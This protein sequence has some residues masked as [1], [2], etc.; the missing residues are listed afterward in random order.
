MEFHMCFLPK[1]SDTCPRLVIEAKLLGCKLQLNDNV[2]HAKEK[3]FDTED[4]EE[5]EKHLREQPKKFWDV[6]QAA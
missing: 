1:G 6:V 2:L 4:I 3:W 5:I